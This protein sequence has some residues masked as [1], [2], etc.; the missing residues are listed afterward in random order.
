M[1]SYP[2]KSRIRGQVYIERE[3]WAQISPLLDQALDLQPPSLE[4][5]LDSLAVQ[6]PAVAAGLRRLLERRAA[7]DSA[8][9]LEEFPP[10]EGL[11]VLEE[12]PGMG[13]VP[14]L[15][16]GPYVLETQIGQGGMGTVWRASG[17]G[18]VHRPAVALKLLRTGAHGP[19]LIERFARERDILASLEHPHIARLYDAGV[20]QN[21]QPY[22]ALEYVAGERLDQYCDTHRLTVRQRLVLIGQIL[23]AV[24]FAHGR[25]VVHRDLKP[26]N[27]LVT[28]SGE[29]RLLDFGV[30]KLLR[31]PDA[32]DP[33]ATALTLRAMTPRY[34][35]PEQVM[36]KTITVMTD[37]YALGVILYE[38]LTGHSPYKV[39]RES[40]GAYELAILDSD[41]A[42]PSQNITAQATE[43]RAT[44]VRQLRRMLRGDLDTIVLKALRK[45]PGERYATADSFRRDIERFLAG[46]AVLARPDTFGYRLR[47][48]VARNRVAAAAAAFAFAALATG[49]ALALVQTHR[50]DTQARIAQTE[51]ATAQAVQ[52]FMEDI[53]K[54]NTVNQPD[55]TRAQNTTA[56]ALLDI[57]A[58]KIDA[59]LRDAPA[60]KLRVLSTLAALYDDLSLEAKEIELARKR[61]QIARDHFGPTSA[62]LAAALVDLATVTSKESL[63]KECDAA[64]A[65]AKRILDSRG[66]LISETRAKYE[67]DVANRLYDTHSN[68]SE[69]HID[70]GIR[71]LRTIPPSLALID[72]LSLKA[73]I[74]NHFENYSAAADAASAAIALAQSPQLQGQSFLPF[75]Y[76]ELAK[77]RSGQEDIVSAEDG[78]RH[79]VAVSAAIYGEDNG[80][81]LMAE[82]ALGNLLLSSSRIS[83]ALAV[84][85]KARDVSVRIAATGDSSSF[86]SYAMN[87][88]ARAL[89]LYGR[90]EEALATVNTIEDMR[91]N[92]ETRADLRASLL[93]R[94]A[95]GLLQ[96]GRYAQVERVINEAEDIRRPTGQEG[97]AQLN[98]IALLRSRLMIFRGDTAGARQA[99][100][101]FSAKPPTQGGAVSREYLDLLVALGE[102][103]LAESHADEA[104]SVGKKALALIENSPMRRFE[105]LWEARCSLIVG[106]AYLLQHRAAEAI[107]FLTRGAQL[108][109]Q[110]FDTAASPEL[111]AAYISLGSAMLEVRER[112]RAQHL[113]AQ[114]GAILHTHTEIGTQFSDPLRQLEA[115][116]H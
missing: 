111:A 46:H 41:P 54:A 73:A 94:R 110:L 97:A 81:T 67:I 95:D 17:G 85:R 26:S 36:G 45:Q 64:L 63:H 42:A 78:M 19:E 68:Q 82:D 57:G 27:V 116:L 33:L 80:N 58:Q 52:T 23:E 31:A 40:P 28:S 50:A 7:V 60:A 103:N 1:S 59:A 104:L 106:R 30:A 56:R 101:A 43:S 89:L 47:K 96:L 87:R 79:A 2:A 32:A 34:A 75:S 35:A 37:V 25:L 93:E 100:R 10:L 70:Q 18:G 29:V 62:E 65:E 108:S 61:V 38:L 51:A 92:L 88:Y 21:G 48:V 53:F 98:T 11:A 113:A 91:R 9:F 13:F 86:P 72:A 49:L 71:L 83:D 109:A 90:F 115:R 76:M 15:R 74:A 44:T 107:P 16:V 20:A 8:E 22:L 55:P 12:S 112:F 24:A 3:E 114:A 105:T 4:Q 66:D 102:I 5:W 14:G 39:A 6:Q 99:L 69:A 84:L 77:A